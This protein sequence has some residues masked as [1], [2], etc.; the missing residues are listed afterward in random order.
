MR[1]LDKNPIEKSDPIAEKPPRWGRTPRR[2]ADKTSDLASSPVNSYSRQQAIGQITA[3]SSSDDDPVYT[4]KTDSR[5]QT[6]SIFKTVIRRRWLSGT[7]FLSL[8]LAWFVA[9]LLYLDQL[10]G[11]QQITTMLPDELGLFVAGFTTPIILLWIGLVFIHQNQSQAAAI[12][13][14]EVAADQ[15][16]AQTRSLF[17]SEQ[18]L[19]LD[20]YL[21]LTDFYLTEMAKHAAIIAVPTLGLSEKR[22]D[23]CWTRFN[24]GDREVFFRLFFE[25]SQTNLTIKL[26]TS[27]ANNDIASRSAHL[28]SGYWQVFLLQADEVDRSNL[29]LEA[30]KNGFLGLLTCAVNKALYGSENPFN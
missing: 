11:L 27:I 14:W 4:D 9:G 8:T 12:Q 3:T 22:L 10:V 18:H 20:T 17:V 1:D 13:A 23:A 15:A 19:R 21:K 26:K 16:R 30:Y 25:P 2:R 6:N 5:T 7:F 28:F 24:Q 29:M